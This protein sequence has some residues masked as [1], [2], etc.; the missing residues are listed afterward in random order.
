MDTKGNMRVAGEITV[1]K[2]NIDESQE[3]EKS[4]GRAVITAGKTEVEVKTNA[5][6]P[7]SHVFVSSDKPT[8]IGAVIEDPETIKILIKKQNQED[9]KVNWW[10][11]N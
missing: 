6:T 4:V 5:L 8:E 7:K 10:I 3:S 11:V 1:K 2:I 9:I